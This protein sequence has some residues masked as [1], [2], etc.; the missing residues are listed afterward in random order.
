[1]GVNLEFTPMSGRVDPVVTQREAESRV[2]E[3]VDRRH[4][5]FDEH[6]EDAK[7]DPFP[8]I[9]LVANDPHPDD[10]VPA[11]TVLA[12]LRHVLDGLEG[13]LL[14]AG[15]LAGLTWREL[16]TP[17]GLGA[18]SKQAV[19]GR[20]RRSV[21][22]TASTRAARE[23][24]TEPS[25]SAAQW[26]VAHGRELEAA[27]CALL[28]ARD[29]LEGEDIQEDLDDLAVSLE[30][31]PMQE[32]RLRTKRIGL[33]A[34]RIHFL[35]EDITAVRTEDAQAAVDLAATLSVAYRVTT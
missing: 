1:M 15:H 21:E 14:K 16:G 31:V 18:A 13:E 33:V 29:F 9:K 8:L 19:R 28:A 11:L 2:T 4:A 17:L 30:S 7:A 20:M 32:G 3:I 26:V 27:T 24:E 6:L 25:L 10:I 12:H 34:S 35:L 22:R 23:S 5:T